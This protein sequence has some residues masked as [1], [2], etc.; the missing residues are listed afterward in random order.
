VTTTNTDLYTLVAEELAL[1]SNGETLDANTSDMISRRASRVRAWLIEEGLCFWLDDAI[2]DAAALPYAQVVAGQC[3]EAFGRGPNS[4][5][6]YLL[7]ETGYRL[8]ERYVSQR[9]SKEPVMVEYF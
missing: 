5:T 9:S 7:G 8:L 2:P 3:A 1:I 4:D 6:P